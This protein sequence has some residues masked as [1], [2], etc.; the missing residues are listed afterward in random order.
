MVTL[1]EAREQGKMAE[2]I[3]ERSDTPPG[4][5]ELTSRVVEE[6]AKRSKAAPR[7][8]RRRDRDG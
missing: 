1:R 2:F 8:S 3:K 6:M 4:D 7:A 5:A